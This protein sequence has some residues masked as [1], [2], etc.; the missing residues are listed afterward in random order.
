MTQLRLRDAASRVLAAYSEAMLV[1][2]RLYYHQPMASVRCVSG[3]WGSTYTHWGRCP[4]TSSQSPCRCQAVASSRVLSELLW[5]LLLAAASAA[6]PTD[7]SAAPPSVPGLETSLPIRRDAAVH[8]AGNRGVSAEQRKMELYRQLV[9]A[10]ST[11]H[12]TTALQT[13]SATY[14]HSKGKVS[15]TL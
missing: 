8:R 2:S 10:V 6:D 14:E 4:E 9:A 15:H 7:P 5:M 12:W 3:M 11:E 1:D 13:H